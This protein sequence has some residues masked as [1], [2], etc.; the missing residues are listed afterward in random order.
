MQTTSSSFTSPSSTT[1]FAPEAS[2]SPAIAALV[3]HKPTLFA[4]PQNTGF[5]PTTLCESHMSAG[6]PQL[7][8]AS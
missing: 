6:L 4:R 5:T 1:L 8:F 3:E 7:H 2:P